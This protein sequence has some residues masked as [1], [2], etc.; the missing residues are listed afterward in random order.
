MLGLPGAP[1]TDFNGFYQ[2]LIPDG[3]SG[4]IVPEKEHYTFDPPVR[5]FTV[6]TTDIKDQDFHG[7]RKIDPPLYFYGRQVLNR[8]LSQAEYIHILTWQPN[9]GNINIEKYRIYLD[10]G[11]FIGLL[12]E[13]NESV[14]EYRHR[15]IHKN[16]SYTYSLAAVDDQGREGSPAVTIIR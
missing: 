15:N 12:A 4:S 6:V 1:K 7:T 16:R 3:W 9:P 13:M 10:D 5:E 11:Q 2:A 14:F 8:S